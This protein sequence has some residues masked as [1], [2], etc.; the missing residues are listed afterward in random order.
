E[1]LCTV[2]CTPPTPAACGRITLADCCRFLP[3]VIPLSTIRFE[4]TNVPV[5]WAGVNCVALTVTV[6]DP[7]VTGAKDV[8]ALPNPGAITI[9]VLVIVPTAVLLLTTL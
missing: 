1:L 9:G 6:V 7:V 3:T 2:T 5:T 8:D 4:L